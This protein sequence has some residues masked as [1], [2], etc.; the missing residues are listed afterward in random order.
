MTWPCKGRMR[1]SRTKQYY[2]YSKLVLSGPTKA[3]PKAVYPVTPMHDISA[4][5]QCWLAQDIEFVEIITVSRHANNTQVNI[6]LGTQERASSSIGWFNGRSRQSIDNTPIKFF[7]KKQ[8][9]WTHIS[10]NSANIHRLA[11][12]KAATKLLILTELRS[13]SC[14]NYLLAALCTVSL[15]ASC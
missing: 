8:M 4:T 7:I 14:K 2:I 13:K 12:P 10:T 15:I 1:T 5:T 11:I 9:K 3:T 6:A